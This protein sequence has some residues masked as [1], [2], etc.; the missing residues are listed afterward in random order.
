MRIDHYPRQVFVVYEMLNDLQC[1]RDQKVRSMRIR[2][3][4][5]YVAKNLLIASFDSIEKTLEFLGSFAVDRP[6]PDASIQAPS[7]LVAVV[8]LSNVLHLEFGA[9]FSDGRERRSSYSCTSMYMH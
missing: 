4:H 6:F 5:C 2:K 3:G 9:F 1:R 7:E 8:D